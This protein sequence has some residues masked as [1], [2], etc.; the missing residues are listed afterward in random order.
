MAQ[1]GDSGKARFRFAPPDWTPQDAVEI[2]GREGLELGE[3]HWETLDALQAYYARHEG[4]AI[5]RRALHDALEEK[6]HFKGGLR[7]LYTLFP[8]GPI[9]Q[10]CRLAGL[11]PPPGAFDPS[12]GSVA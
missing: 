6:F 11:E 2:A 9:A 1:P 8:G 7:Y 4:E 3:D 5:R 10:G 12:Y